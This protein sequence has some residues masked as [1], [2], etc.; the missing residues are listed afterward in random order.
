LTG[1]SQLLD[2]PGGPFGRLKA[3]AIEPIALQRA[4]AQLNGAAIQR[5]VERTAEL[6]ARIATAADSHDL[7]SLSRRDVREGCA[8]FLHPPTPPGRN[9]ATGDA[10]V[11]EVQRLRRR[12]AF[13]S[14]INA[15]LD[16]FEP[17]DADVE[18]LGKQITRL[19]ADWPWRSG[20]A[21]PRR[22]AKYALF[23]AGLAPQ[24]ISAAV[25]AS[26]LPTRAVLS[27][28]GLDTDG[29]RRG[30]LAEAA[31]RAACLEVGRSSGPPA[32]TRQVKIVDWAEV[33]PDTIAFPGSWPGFAAALFQPWR[34]VE[35]P[36]DHKR[37]LIETAVAFAGDPRVREARWRPVP[38]ESADV[39]MR[40]LT[41]ASVEQF[42]EIVSETMTDRPDMWI[43][44]RR[45][46]TAYLKANLIDAAWVVFGADGARRADH[47]ARRLSDQGL[48][49]F[50]RLASGGNRTSEHA[51]LIMKIGDLTVAEW[52]HNGS[53]NIWR[54]GDKGH[55]PLFRHN[56]RHR[57]DY[58][59][60]ELMT[61]PLRGAHQSTWQWKVAEIIRTQ[62]GRR[63]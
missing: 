24:R 27:D 50:G 47:A 44:R 23:N 22:A 39:V 46:W 62:T 49:M 2:T 10:L 26:E 14:L 52:S 55:P 9:I 30:G 29:R 8:V 15:Y 1:L 59:P 3:R 56:D 32:I 17:T 61:A 43:Q 11:D 16:G 31:F 53:W 13:F 25:F 20:D 37:L 6:Q 5:N 21:W 36:P 34:G 4:A 60:K 57:P 28:A 41:K 54:P 45:F 40:W 7:R 18:R 33:G 38:K 63:P 12:A 19:S 51:A 48:S 58:T 35:P 42:F